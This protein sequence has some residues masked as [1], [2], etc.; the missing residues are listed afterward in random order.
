LVMIPL[1]SFESRELKRR[2][3]ERLA[4]NQQLS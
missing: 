2:I 1:A 3:N 4:R